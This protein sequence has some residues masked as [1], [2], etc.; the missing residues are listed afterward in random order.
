MARIGAPALAVVGVVLFGGGVAAGVLL[1]RGGP[2]TLRTVTV[3]APPAGGTSPSAPPAPAAAA[4]TSGEVAAENDLASA[5]V[6][7]ADREALRALLARIPGPDIPSGT[8]SLSGKVTRVDGSPVAGVRV[9][10]RANP[11]PRHGER[12]RNRYYF[13]DADP[14][15]TVTRALDSMRWYA[16]TTREGLSAEDGAYRIEGLIDAEY[17]LVPPEKGWTFQPRGGGGRGGRFRAGDVVDILATPTAEVDLT[18]LLPDGSP[19]KE[20]TL[21]GDIPGGGRTGSSWTPGGGPVSLPVGRHE[22]HVTA[23]DQQE[24]RSDP[25][26]LELKEGAPPLPLVVSLR[27]RPGVRGRIEFAPGEEWPWMQVALARRL[28][29]D[30][31]DAAAIRNAALKTASAH[32]HDGFRFSFPDLPAGR[33]VLA[34]APNDAPAAAVQEVEVTSAMVDCVLRMPPLPREAYILATLRGPEGIPVG[35]AQF[36]IGYQGKRGSSTNGANVLQRPD[37]SRWLLIPESVRRRGDEQ[38][39]GEWW[40]QAT[41]R[42]HGTQRASFAPGPAPEVSFLFAEPATVVLRIQGY[43]GSALE[44]RVAATLQPA[45]ADGAMIHSGRDNENVPDGDGRRTLTAV[46]PGEYEVVITPAQNPWD[47]LAASPVSVRSGTQEIVVPLPAL[48]SLVVTGGSG[49]VHASQR[50]DS[51]GG[52][53]VGGRRQRRISRSAQVGANGIAVLDLLPEGE[54]SV[55]TSGK[56]AQIV[57]VPGTTE[58]RF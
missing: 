24:F 40:V 12:S 22:V 13:E 57:K 10:V 4:A 43:A 30:L 49:Q 46:Q 42:T 41:S 37:G 8:G 38:E 11:P 3:A 16:G 55:N 21:W 23:G 19:P 9:R 51:S 32:A 1:A 53:P 33:Y 27:G 26:P 6:P 14:L 36:T 52:G 15:E 17:W 50:S 54:Y 39:G 34:A 45:S 31:P 58:V 18:V 28:P 7:A 35:D 20:A 56:P 25:T 29:G 48:H 44:G 2:P 5:A 47:V